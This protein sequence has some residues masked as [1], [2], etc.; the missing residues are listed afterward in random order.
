[1]KYVYYCVYVIVVF[2][3]GLFIIQLYSCSNILFSY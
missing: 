3:R 1:M 2:A